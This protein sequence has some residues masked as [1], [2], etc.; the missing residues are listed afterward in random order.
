MGYFE[1]CSSSFSL[2]SYVNTKTF[3]GKQRHIKLLH[4]SALDG[5]EVDPVKI[6]ETKGCHLFCTNT[7]HRPEM[8]TYLCVA[9]KRTIMAFELTKTRQKHRKLREIPIAGQVQFLDLWGDSL[10]VGYQSTFVIYNILNEGAP[11]SLI[12]TEDSQLQFLV[13]APV[14]SMLAVEVSDKEYLLAFSGKLIFCLYVK[15]LSF[16]LFSF[17]LIVIW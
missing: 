13:H 10:C 15:S 1:K 11:F 8:N 6:Q 9:I 16:F 7:G 17:N 2:R 14:D 4:S 12:N 5:Y 3:P